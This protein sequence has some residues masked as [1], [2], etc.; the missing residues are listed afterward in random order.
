MRKI[1]HHQLASDSFSK[2]ESF[3]VN[4]CHNLLNVFPS[5]M[6]GRLQKLEVLC[7]VRC[8]AVEEIFEEPNI[9]SCKMEG[10][11][12]KEEDIEAVPFVFPQLNWLR[13][14]LLPKLRCFYPRLYISMWPVLRILKMVGCEKVERLASHYRSLQETHGV[15][16]HENPQRPFFI[17][18]QVREL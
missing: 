13:L 14:S 11:V 2:I 8:N 10:I 1:W 3:G 17:F 6:I 15:S 7:V 4:D 16:P 18:D 12:T 9:L 5:N